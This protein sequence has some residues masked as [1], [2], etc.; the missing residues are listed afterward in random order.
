[1]NNEGRGAGA[2]P[3]VAPGA[4]A[5][6]AAAAAGSVTGGL[7]VNALAK[8]AMLTFMLCKVVRVIFCTSIAWM[9]ALSAVVF[10]S[11]QNNTD[12]NS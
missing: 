6:S 8:S 2:E 10:C 1:M 3:A 9:V 5:A 11:N 7:T 4:G 12:F